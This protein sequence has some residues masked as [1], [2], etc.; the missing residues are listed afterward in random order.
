MK[1][2]AKRSC[3]GPTLNFL[4]CTV[5]RAP[6]FCSPASGSAAMDWTTSWISSRTLSGKARLARANRGACRTKR[7]G[8]A[9]GIRNHAPLVRLGQPGPELRLRLE[10]SLD[11]RHGQIRVV[12]GD[13]GQAHV[14]IGRASC[15]EKG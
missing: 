9:S 10:N 4:T 7:A 6:A 8:V 5:L 13:G 2:E 14:E 12:L 1:V 15:M 3:W 11:H